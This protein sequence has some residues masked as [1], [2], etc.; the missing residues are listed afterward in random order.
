MSERRATE[1]ERAY[2]RRLAEANAELA[3]D[4]RPAASLA[5]VFERMESM[6]RRLGPL[7]GAG[8][9]PDDEAKLAELRALRARFLRRPSGGA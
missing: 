3:R 1:R 7:A 4:E 6:R 2:W 8:L 5:E 9:P